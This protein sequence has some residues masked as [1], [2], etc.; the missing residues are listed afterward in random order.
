MWTYK[1]D[2]FG[3][4]VPV[5]Q[6]AGNQQRTTSYQYDAEGRVTWIES[7]EG[8][9]SYSYDSQGRRVR[10]TTV[11]VN[12]APQ[13]ANITNDFRYAYDA[14]GRLA[15]VSVYER[16]DVP[17][18]QPDVTSN[19]YDLQGNLDLE[20][21]ANGV[22]TDYAYDTL[23]RL[24]VLTHYA[25]DATPNDLSDNAKLTS[26]DYTV[27][28]DGRRTGV[29]EKFWIDGAEKTNNIA[30]SYDPLSRLVDEVFQHY[31]PTLTHDTQC[32][33]TSPATGW[34]SGSTAATTG[35]WMRRPVTV[36]T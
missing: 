19:R 7:P 33:T 4:T 18:S 1:Y 20:F 36:T 32:S 9:V 22:I 5:T 26:F 17:L 10:A 23:S 21:E 30:W 3:R 8:V 35:R 31:D 16:N 28:A 29:V 24:D 13:T 6:A 34:N 25:P 15:S 12:P 2:A 27:R 11:V 14:L